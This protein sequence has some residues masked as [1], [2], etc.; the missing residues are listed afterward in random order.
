M[1]IK[2]IYGK[3]TEDGAGI[4]TSDGMMIVSQIIDCCRIYPMENES[5]WGFKAY[6]HDGQMIAQH[7]FSVDDNTR[8]YI[9]DRGKTVDVLPQR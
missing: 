4:A 7:K 6:D 8:A 1:I 3:T 5:Q 9:T 2:V